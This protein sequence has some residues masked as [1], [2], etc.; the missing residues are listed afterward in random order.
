MYQLMRGDSSDSDLLNSTTHY[1]PVP[2]GQSV[3]SPQRPG[4]HE[5]TQQPT[6]DSSVLSTETVNTKKG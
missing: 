3:F 4:E 1:V 5:E 6:L 2:P